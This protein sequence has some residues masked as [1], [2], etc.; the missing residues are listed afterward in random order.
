MIVGKK[1]F[2]LAVLSFLLDL[3]KRLLVTLVNVNLSFLFIT[4]SAMI[5]LNLVEAAE[6]NLDIEIPDLDL[7]IEA[8]YPKLRTSGYIKNETAYRYREPRSYTKIRNT[9]QVESSYEV[10]ESSKFHFVGRAYHDVVYD[11]FDYDTITARNTRE[12]EQPLA[13]VENLPQEKDSNVAEI[14][15]LYV[16][17]RNSWSDMRVGKQFVVWGVLPGV[18]VV[19][20]LNPMDFKELIT[21]SLLDYRISLWSLKIDTYWRDNDF[22]L[23]WIPDIKFHKP[24]PRGSEW[25]LFQEVPGTEFPNA[26]RL[27]NSEVG[28]RVKRTVFGAEFSLSY[29]YTWDDFPVL[30]REALVEQESGQGNTIIEP[31]LFP[32]YKRMHMLGGTFQHTIKGQIINAEGAFVR[33]KYFGLKAIDRDKDGYLDH[34]GVLKRDHVRLGLGLD[35]NIFQA[36]I[37]PSVTQWVIFNYDPAILQDKY[38][39]SFNLFIRKTFTKRSAVFEML[40]IFLFN[41]EEAYIKPKFSFR[42]DSQFEIAV[43]LDLFYGDKSKLGVI[44][45]DGRPTDLLV[46]S[47]SS[48]FIGNFDQND[49]L[50]AEFKYSF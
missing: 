31:K 45:Q 38:D 26:A 7:A 44:A 15:E 4:T 36:E 46:V 25:E 1:F 34:Q 13:F 40:S 18:R 43:G 6:K 33:G 21:P 23:V 47:Q 32:A 3:N 20:E 49:R 2:H 41:L 14:R 28:L 50:F 10:D 8:S 39:T 48:Q 42:P 12:I 17:A 9:L 29:F 30:F 5:S 19:D 35:F 24:A 37:S 16:E 11:L 22:Q 27:E